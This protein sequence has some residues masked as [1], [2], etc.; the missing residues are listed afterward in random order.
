MHRCVRSSAAVA[1]L[2][3]CCRAPLDADVPGAGRHFCLSCSKYFVSEAALASHQRGKP[4]K[5]RLS[6]LLKLRTAGMQPH[7][8]ADAEKAGGLGGTDNGLQHDRE[9]AAIPMID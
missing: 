7:S 1:E 2:I 5:R 4:H 3:A 6:Q 9:P 8:A